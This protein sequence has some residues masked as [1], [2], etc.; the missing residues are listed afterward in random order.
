[1]DLDE[2]TSGWVEKIWN[3]QDWDD[4]R[5]R[6]YLSYDCWSPHIG[7]CTLTG[8]DYRACDIGVNSGPAQFDF[9]SALSPSAFMSY[10]NEN[11]E[12][13]EQLL[14]R[15]NEDIDRL[16]GFWEN[17]GNDIEDAHYPP[18]FFIEWASLKNFTPDWLDWA[19][20]R[21][22]Y[23]PKQ[24]ADKTP[25]SDSDNASL[26]PPELAMDLQA[27]ATAPGK[28]PN[29]T[30][31]K[32]AIKAAWEIECATSK[33]ATAYQVIEKLQ[34][35]EPDEPVIREVIAHGVKWVTKKGKT[36]KYDIQTCAKTLETWNA[37]RV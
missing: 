12:A 6:D 15:M 17:S 4:S 36:N 9:A 33:R 7:L 25:L 24:E 23:I 5:L 19:I 14:S 21:E 37:S 31:G 30:I 32:L 29:T 3:G 20:E 34:E 35:W 10:K 1:M 2:L 8:F 11:S 16:R 27:G 22:L 13:E 26:S 28:M 18:A